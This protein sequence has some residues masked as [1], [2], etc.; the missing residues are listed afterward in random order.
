[1]SRQSKLQNILGIKSRR[2]QMLKE[3]RALK[4]I[5]TPPEVKIE[6][7]DLEAEIANLKTELEETS[8]EPANGTSANVQTDKNGNEDKGAI[9]WGKIS[10]IAG[11]AAVIIAIIML[12]ISPDWR[13]GSNTATPTQQPTANVDLSSDA[14]A[15]TVAL[16]QTTDS[17][18]TSEPA[19]DNTPTTHLPT[20]TKTPQPTQPSPTPT[21]LKPTVTPP[22]AQA[23]TPQP[24]PSA[25][26][27]AITVIAPEPK[28]VINHKI[29]KVRWRCNGSV[30]KDYGFEVKLWLPGAT[31][32]GAHDA[33][34]DQKHIQ[35]WGGDYILQIG[36]EDAAG[37]DGHGKDYYVAVSLVRISPKYED[38]GLMSEPVL[39]SYP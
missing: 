20:P 10:A 5:N 17:A 16:S 11:V 25:N 13:R 36:V 26:C 39:F 4:G 15:G 19:T 7:E 35:R 28:G 31:P 12:T 3:E 1:M 29:L 33:I 21:T 18:P 14:L 24:S 6:I 38:T 37:Y 8:A 34:A 2:L 23:D 30:P 32:L 22:L 9:N 27:D